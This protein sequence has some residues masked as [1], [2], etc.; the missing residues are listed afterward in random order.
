MKKIVKKILKPIIPQ[1]I[2]IYFK[3]TNQKKEFQKWID[4][5]KPAPA[6]HIVKQETIKEYQEKYGCSVFVETGTYLGDMVEAQKRNFEKLFSIELG[7][8]LYENAKKRF[9]KNQKIDILQGDSGKVL[10]QIMEKIDKTT[11]FWLDGHYSAGIT[12]QGDKDCPIMEELSSILNNDKLNHVLLIDDARCFIGE[13]DYPTI[14]SLTKFVSQ[15]NDK[16]QVEVK[17]DI[18]RFTVN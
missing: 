10:P 1:S 17:D 3:K 11:L 13:G 2:Y 6:P 16:Y 18:I 5:G 14:E 8:K 12:A 15:K 7:K 9:E 4:N